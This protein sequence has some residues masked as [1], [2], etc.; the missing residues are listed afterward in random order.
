[1]LSLGTRDVYS[2]PI[3]EDESDQRW[4]TAENRNLL[5]VAFTMFLIHCNHKAKRMPLLRFDKMKCINLAN[6]KKFYGNS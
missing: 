3:N 6:C 4:L 1:M 2:Y 5:S